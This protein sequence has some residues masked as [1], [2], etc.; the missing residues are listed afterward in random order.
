MTVNF[1][2][3][4]YQQLGFMHLTAHVKIFSKNESI[5]DFSR[6][7]T[8]IYKWKNKRSLNSH[9]RYLSFKNGLFF[10]QHIAGSTHNPLLRILDLLLKI[11]FELIMLFC[12]LLAKVTPRQY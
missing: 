8:T 9:K 4:K 2:E 11:V 12:E 10:P 1:N 5:F 6:L 7:R 3:K